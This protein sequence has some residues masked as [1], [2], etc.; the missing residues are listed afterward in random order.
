MADKRDGTRG[1][2]LDRD[3][4]EREATTDL[5]DTTPDRPKGMPL[6]T[7]ILIGL[8][9]GVLAG[10]ASYSLFSV[11]DPASPA[12]ISRTRGSRRSSTTSP[13]RSGNSSF[14]CC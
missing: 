4:Y 13:S 11:P 14:G 12:T 5:K 7:R 3:A 9:V 2:G 6:H 10:V 1:R 8:G